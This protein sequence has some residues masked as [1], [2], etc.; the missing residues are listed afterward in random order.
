MVKAS[1]QNIINAII[2]EISKGL[3][4]GKVMGTIGKKWEISR[5][6]FDRYWKTANE[7]HAELQQKAKAAADKSYI[8]TSEEL[9][10]EAVMSEAEAKKHI[11]DIAKSNLA[12]YMVIKKVERQQRIEVGLQVVID[13]LN[14]QIKFEDEFAAVAGYSDDEIKHHRAAQASRK[15]EVLRYK[16]ML[17]KD[18]SATTIIDG[19][20][21]WEEVAD[22]DMVKI[23][24]DKVQG[25]IK[26]LAHT[27]FGIKVEMYAADS[28][29]T[30]ILKLHGAFAKDNEQANPT[31]KQ[32]FV[33]NGKEVQF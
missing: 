14:D 27:Q 33:I 17:K 4:R 24:R 20:T 32:F 26:S 23:V 30:T 10:K 19:P 9:A 16:I 7:Q 6:T 21:V 29:L 15:R 28:A 3:G 2:K 13:S 18:K 11:T 31:P 5:T 8:Q 1:K 25:K 22:L 12:D